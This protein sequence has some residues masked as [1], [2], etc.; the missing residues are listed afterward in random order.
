M[1]LPAQH[2][3]DAHQGLATAPELAALARHAIGT[4]F[5]AAN[6]SDHRHAR[7]AAREGVERYVHALRVEGM[8]REATMHRVAEL[9]SVP[10]PHR[11]DARYVHALRVELARWSAAAYDGR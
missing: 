3:H 9:L 11:G 7:L 10:V 4:L 8:S 2:Q 6:Y 5:G 1:P